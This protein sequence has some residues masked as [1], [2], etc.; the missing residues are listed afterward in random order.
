MSEKE[1]QHDIP[2]FDKPNW[3]NESFD[4][5]EWFKFHHLK[6]LKKYN[7][8]VKEQYDRLRLGESYNAGEVQLLLGYLDELIKLYD[9]LPQTTGGTHKMDKL[10]ADRKKLEGIYRNN[11]DCYHLV[12]EIKLKVFTICNYMQAICDDD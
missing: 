12:Q 3:G 4:Y 10:I 5:F 11:E 9:Y 2:A 6:T 8:L 1:P 7:L